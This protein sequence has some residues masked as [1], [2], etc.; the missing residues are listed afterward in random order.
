MVIKNISLQPRIPEQQLSGRFRPPSPFEAQ[1][2]SA[3]LPFG[4][5]G[6][7]EYFFAVVAWNK[8]KTMQII[9]D[10]GEW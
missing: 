8:S 7:L 5:N 4:G 2:D 10:H 9:L 6:V 1:M 3:S